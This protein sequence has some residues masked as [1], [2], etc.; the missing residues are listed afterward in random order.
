MRLLLFI[1]L[2]LLPPMAH[3]QWKVQ[4]L[5]TADVDI[6]AMGVADDLVIWASRPTSSLHPLGTGPL[7]LQ[8]RQHVWSFDTLA[9]TQLN[10]QYDGQF[11]VNSIVGLGNMAIARMLVAGGYRDTC[12][13]PND[14]L[15][16]YEPQSLDP[17]LMRVNAANGQPEWVWS[18]S[19]AGNNFIHKI[20]YPYEGGTQVLAS[21][22]FNDTT[23]WMAAFDIASGQLLWEKA[24]PGVRT[25]SDLHFGVLPNTEEVIFTGTMT[26]SGYLHHLPVPLSTL[27]LTGYR[28]F[29]ASYWP[30]TDSVAFM[31]STPCDTFSFEPSL[32]SG[33][34]PIVWSTPSLENGLQRKLMVFNANPIF[35]P[36]IEY[37]EASQ[38][39]AELDHPSGPSLLPLFFYQGTSAAPDQHYLQYGYGSLNVHDTLQLASGSSPGR[40][41]AVSEYATTYHTIKTTGDLQLRRGWAGSSWVNYPVE[42]ASMQTPRWVVIYDNTVSGSVR[43]NHQLSFSIYPNPNNIGLVRVQWERE[44]DLPSNWRL[45]D[46]QGKLLS[47]GSLVAGENNLPLPQLAPGIYLLELEQSTRKGW[48]RLVIY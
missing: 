9:P 18:R 40:A 20:H 25:L 28:S 4:V 46:L 35:P 39:H 13:L 37:Y 41:A 24:W 45:H 12:Y 30:S 27:P 29:V 32:M 48:Q 38:W 36:Q 43:E 44:I 2:L 14:T 22:Q 7:R 6:T 10:V 15:I 23:G 17:F 21:G 8:V 42:G 34:H 16:G 26:D 31:A 33:F 5:D 11:R 3:A 19:Q 47:S 1:T